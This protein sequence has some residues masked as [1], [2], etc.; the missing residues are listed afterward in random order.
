MKR[1]PLKVIVIS[2]LLSFSAAGSPWGKA[3]Q[4]QEELEEENIEIQFQKYNPPD[5]LE[6]SV[7]VSIRWSPGKSFDHFTE[8]FEPYELGIT[9]DVLRKNDE[10]KIVSQAV[11]WMVPSNEDFEASTTLVFNPE[12][13]TE[14]RLYFGQI[15]TGIVTVILSEFLKGFPK[16]SESPLDA[17]KDPF[18]PFAENP[19]RE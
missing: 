14:V 12:S 4:Y 7:L 16:R 13:L 19:G 6:R 15:D 8:V 11:S 17:S 2:M 18:D 10:G 5:G 9:I 3:I 1:T